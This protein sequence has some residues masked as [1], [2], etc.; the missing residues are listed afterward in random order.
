MS[1]KDFEAIAHI[2][3]VNMAPLELVQ[4]FADQFAEDNPRFNRALFI[5][6]AT[7]RLMASNAA[8]RRI[9]EEETEA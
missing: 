3:N 8:Q 6:V 5:R 9:F 7:V 2:L 4:D 1:K